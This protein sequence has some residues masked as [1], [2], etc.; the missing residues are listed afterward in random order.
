[1]TDPRLEKPKTPRPEPMPTLSELGE[2]SQLPWWLLVGLA[3]VVI[4][5]GVYVLLQP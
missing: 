1:M 2:S 4:A 5:A 3:V